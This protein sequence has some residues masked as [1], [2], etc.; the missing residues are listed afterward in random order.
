MR[1]HFVVLG[2]IRIMKMW[3]LLLQTVG[4]LN[5]ALSVMGCYALAITAAAVSR[6]PHTDPSEPYF[7][8]SFWIMSAIDAA[9]LIVFVF[10]S[11][12]L[13]RLHRWA[14]I[15]HTCVVLALIVYAF[16][17]G[18]LW[19]L[20]HGVGE[21]IAGASGVGNMGVGTLLF[22]PVP[23]LY[24]LISVVCVNIARLRLKR[25]TAYPTPIIR[26]V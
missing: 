11:I 6:H 10:V 7:Y 4:A 26:D 24:P 8:T 9:F 21:S 19:L 15:A 20:P 25:T 12:M 23:F 18:L 14:A 3:R 2:L 13:L 16:A 22:F 5:L 1:K 17:P